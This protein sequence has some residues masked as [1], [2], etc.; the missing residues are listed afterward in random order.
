MNDIFDE[1]TQQKNDIFDR[2]AP[3]SS[4]VRTDIFDEVEG[5]G[6]IFDR[7]EPVPAGNV[8]TDVV[9]GV[10]RGWEQGIGELGGLMSAGGEQIIKS[11]KGFTRTPI[12]KKERQPLRW[13]HHHLFR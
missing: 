4:R 5:Q 9:K 2:M 13:R 6:D 1:V 11:G 10:S 12:Q 7:A 3:N 8:A